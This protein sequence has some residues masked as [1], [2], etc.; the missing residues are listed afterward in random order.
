[1]FWVSAFVIVERY[2]EFLCLYFPLF[3]LFQ[4]QFVLQQVREMTG[5]SCVSFKVICGKLDRIVLRF[6]QF[7]FSRV[8]EILGII[9]DM[10]GKKMPMSL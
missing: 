9:L 2:C 4:L 10:A 1:M 7:A 8:Y 6:H 5:V 3:W